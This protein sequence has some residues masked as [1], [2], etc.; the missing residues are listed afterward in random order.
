MLV[1][2][3]MMI[4]HRLCALGIAGSLAACSASVGDRAE[5]DSADVGPA[6]WSADLRISDGDGDARTTYNFAR[7]VATTEDGAVHVAWYDARGAVTQIYYTRSLDGGTT[8]EPPRPIA[9]S[10]VAQ[11]SAAIAASGTT[12]YVAWHEQR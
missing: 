5:V 11:T 1:V 7:D 4:S 12:V 6:T 10:S 8:W 2:P 9:A 3:H